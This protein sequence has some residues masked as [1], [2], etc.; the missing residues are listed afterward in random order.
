MKAIKVIVTLLCWSLLWGC[1]KED[2]HV[3]PSYYENFW[4]IKD[5]PDDPVQ[6]RV[7][8]IYEEYG[9]PVF[10]NDTVGKKFVKT[11]ISGDSVFRYETIDLNWHFSSE[12][13]STR[14]THTYLTDPD[15]CLKALEVATAYLETVPAGIYPFSILLTEKTMEPSFG[16]GT[17][18]VSSGIFFR[19]LLLSDVLKQNTEA[20]VMKYVNKIMIDVILKRMDNN[21]VTR[22]SNVSDE[23][24]YGKR[25]E[26]LES[27]LPENF[28]PDI[29]SDPNAPE[30]DKRAVRAVMGKYG[31][32]SNYEDLDFDDNFDLVYFD[33]APSYP[34][35]DLNDYIKEIV[36]VTP[37]EFERR[38][39]DCPLVMQKYEII[40]EYIPVKE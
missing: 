3:E 30:E 20:K 11:T 32:V 12:S 24:S 25:W 18:S 26:E 37:E 14:Y 17:R 13:Y 10:F 6:H 35:V 7:F 40:R 21:V 33:C 2:I 8:E 31:F 22:F 27:N 9:V 36:A 38:W 28:D 29:L 23:R 19:T 16:G 1:Q 4:E 15:K 34:E 5:N 39:G